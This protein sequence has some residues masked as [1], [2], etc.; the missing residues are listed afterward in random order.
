MT[1]VKTEV[2]MADTE[3]IAAEMGHVLVTIEAKI[4][5]IEAE[6]VTIEAD[7]VMEVAITES[8]IRKRRTEAE[9][10][11]GRNHMTSPTANLTIQDIKPDTPHGIEDAVL[12]IIIN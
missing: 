10:R 9:I 1:V 8:A 11:R 4:I 3:Q 5:T 6:I 2:I 12:A 7:I